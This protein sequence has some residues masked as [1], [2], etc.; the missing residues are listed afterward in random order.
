MAWLNAYEL[1]V[2]RNRLNSANLVETKYLYLAENLWY[3]ITNKGWD[4]GGN[5]WTCGDPGGIVQHLPTSDKPQPDKNLGTNAQY[6]L[7]SAWLYRATG[8]TRFLK[9]P[10]GTSTVGGATAEANWLI[11]TPGNAGALMQHYSPS[12]AFDQPGSRVLFDGQMDPYS[13]PGSCTIPMGEPKETQHM[14]QVIAALASMYQATGNSF[15][16]TVGDNVAETVLNDNSANWYTSPA[17][18]MI[19]SNG[20]LSEDCTPL[21][22]AGPWP[23]GC[24]V[25]GSAN[26]WLPGKGIFIRGLYC[27]SSALHGSDAAIPA[28]ITSNAQW[29]WAADQNTETGNPAAQNLN[30]FGFLWDKF[31]GGSGAGQ[32][33][34]TQGAAL[35]ALSADL[36]LTTSMC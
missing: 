13:N 16:L 4:S 24:D 20:V 6:L 23:D 10:D 31:H 34:A 15:Y 3:Y 32:G 26:V 25:T 17:E 14:G 7:L 8:L 5:P 19:D 22:G 18:P 21:A 35:E 1:S 2:E 11:G 36:G 27:L 9:G 12:P 33:F 30:Q 28:F 29:V